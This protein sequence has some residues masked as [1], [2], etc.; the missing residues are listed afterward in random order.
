MEQGVVGKMEGRC[1][2]VILTRRGDLARIVTAHE[3]SK[4]ER[5]AYRKENL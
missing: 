5:S 4:A 1:L 3:A 2:T